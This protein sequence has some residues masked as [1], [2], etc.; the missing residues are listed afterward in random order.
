MAPN[1]SVPLPVKTSMEAANSPI[2]TNW[3]IMTFS[4]IFT[5]FTE[6]T[7]FRRK[8]P[9]T[10]ATFAAAISVTNP[11]LVNKELKVFSGSRIVV[12]TVIAAAIAAVGLSARPDQHRRAHRTGNIAGL[13]AGHVHRD[14]LAGR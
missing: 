14:K 4:H 1:G 7:G 2:E 8:R 11:V 13:L 5:D 6:K 3:T 9:R 10:K 12:V